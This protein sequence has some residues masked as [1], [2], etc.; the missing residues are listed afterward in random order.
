M[1]GP[2]GPPANC[3]DHVLPE[4]IEDE[5]FMSFI[6]PTTRGRL[7]CVGF[8]FELSLLSYIS[9]HS[10]IILY[11]FYILYKYLYVCL[12]VLLSLTHISLF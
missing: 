1:N 6:Q 2:A 9:L 10:A 11:I 7:R 8:T 3:L 5:R 12:Y 4:I